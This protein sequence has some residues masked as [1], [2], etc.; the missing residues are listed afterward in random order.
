MKK[1]L[2]MIMMVWRVSST[3]SLP[4]IKPFP[5]QPHPLATCVGVLR[6]Q[7]SPGGVCSKLTTSVLCLLSPHVLDVQLI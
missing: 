6:S 7:Q 3:V 1:L 4:C 5:T 2:T